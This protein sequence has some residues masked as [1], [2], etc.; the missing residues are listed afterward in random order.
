VGMRDVFSARS[1]YVEAVEA[2]FA[3]LDL[4]G[5]GRRSIL[6]AVDGHEP[7]LR[8]AAYAVGVARRQAARLV[9]LFV[10]TFGSLGSTADSIYAMRV[11]NASAVV[12][13]RGEMERQ[14]VALGVEITVVECQ[15]DPYVETARLAGQ[16]RVD[17]VVMGSARNFGHHLFGSPV[18]RLVRH[19]QWPITVVP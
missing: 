11:G 2:R 12:A 14:A 15:G 17:G 19:A 7:S 1:R 18:S 8:A 13:L 3:A 6:V 4:C 5:D 9:V 16:L 10:H